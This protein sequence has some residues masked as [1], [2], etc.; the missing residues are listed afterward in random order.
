MC[1]QSLALK[2]T[3][4]TSDIFFYELKMGCSRILFLT[5]AVIGLISVFLVLDDL[6]E[7]RHT[8]Y[9]Y[10]P[11]SVKIILDKV[12][13]LTAGIGSENSDRLLTKE[14]LK[15]YD[16]TTKSQIYLAI[17][18]SVFDV[19]KGDRFYSPGNHYGGFS[20]KLY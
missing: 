8:L 7:H 3:V 17:L 16:G 12:A 20:S 5:A 10:A 2:D 18:G 14:E 13:S 11:D 1:S 15:E 6:E 4:E 19:T 9:Q